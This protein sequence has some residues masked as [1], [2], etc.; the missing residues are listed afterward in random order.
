MSSDA[1]EPGAFPRTGSFFA[2][3]GEAGEWLTGLLGN[4]AVY[5]AAGRLLVAAARRHDF[6][7]PRA[8]ADLAELAGLSIREFRHR[9]A[10]LIAEQM[11]PAAGPERFIFRC[12]L[13]NRERHIIARES[14]R[15]GGL[16]RAVRWWLWAGKSAQPDR[17]RHR[18]E[19]ADARAHDLTPREGVM[20]GITR[21]LAACLKTLEAHGVEGEAEAADP[22]VVRQNMRA[23]QDSWFRRIAGIGRKV[24]G[25][26]RG[27]A[28]K[29]APVHLHPILTR[30]EMDGTLTYYVLAC[31]LLF[32]KIMPAEPTGP[33]APA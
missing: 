25:M 11:E 16:V 33:P 4:A 6:T 29:R 7:L 31:V 1:F 30:M 3:A 27:E 22:L 21:R 20:K 2:L 26:E 23:A 19:L 15:K 24:F 14:G 12:Q 28:Q 32:G 5:Q 18:V 17:R 13:A 10:P 9:L 8:D